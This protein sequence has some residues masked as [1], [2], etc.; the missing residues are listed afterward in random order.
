M[1][2][3]RLTVVALVSLATVTILTFSVFSPGLSGPLL[4]DDLPQL[5]ALIEQS[6]DE[7]AALVGKFIISTSGPLGRPVSM[8]TFIADAIGHGPDIWWWKY[9]NLMFHLISGLLVCW[10]TALLLQ[11]LPTKTGTDPWIVAVVV[12]GLW[13]LHPLQVSTVLYTVQRMTELSTLFVLAGLVCYV[14]G[15]L[16][17]D[18]SVRQ[19]WLLIGIGFILFYPLGVFSKE[20]ALV[21]PVYCT[22][23]ELF[24][25]QFRGSASLQRQVKTFHGLLVVGYASV[26]ILILVNFSSIVLDSY[27]YRDFTLSERA[28]TQVRVIV[29]YLSQ[30]LLPIQ[31]NMGFFHDDIAV[32]T[33]LFD[34]VTTLL[35]ALLL[36]ALFASSIALRRRLPLYAFGILFFFTSHV[37]E[38]SILGLELMFEHRNYIGIFGIL[39]ASVAVV[40]ALRPQRQ[41]VAIVSAA[42]LL[43]LSALTWQRS[44][45]WSNPGDMYVYMHNTHPKS[46]RLNLVFSNVYASSGDFDNARRALSI[47]GDDLGTDMHSLF[48]SCLEHR[49]ISDEAMSAIGRSRDGVV[50]GHVTSSVEGLVRE[51]ISGRCEASLQSLV[52][53][54]DH[55]LA[56]PARSATDGAAVLYAKAALLESMND[57]DAAVDQYLKVQQLSSIDAKALYLAAATLIRSGRPDA[58]RKIASRAYALEKTTRAQSGETAEQVYLAL[59]RA[60]EERQQFDNALEVYGEAASSI[61]A[62]SLFY[63]KTAELLLRLRRYD[64]VEQVLAD[65]RGRQLVDLDQY[66]Y[67]MQRLATR[68]NGRN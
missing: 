48:L 19:G 22:L 33:G 31:G 23:I 30:I 51:V 6:A 16:L 21:Y 67:A 10:L 2:T 53:V 44:Q 49:R 7:P 46:P 13:L 18:R 47:V 15:R 42:I 39:L 57:I 61:P 43:G 29:M 5:N 34:P 66:E 8:A 36:F 25:L 56:S 68:L 11:K 26:A 45:T 60:Y 28:F 1:K 3:D 54:L 62:R 64:E 12:A 4:L 55:V 32:S 35:S 37:L 17:H 59:G 24:V 14:K 38:S 9:S 27:A 50:D 65:M 41:S 20:N 63:L 40:L 58:A 52:Q